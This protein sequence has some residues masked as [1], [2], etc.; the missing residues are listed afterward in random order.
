MGYNTVV[1]V[2][3]DALDV[4]RDDP[5]FG[6]HLY[7]AVVTRDR[8]RHS[9]DVP[10]FSSRGGIFCNAASVLSCEHADVPQVAVI[11]GNTGWVAK[12]KEEMPEHA[13][14]DMIWILEQHGYKVSKAKK[15]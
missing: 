3:N 4:I 6:Q 1:V 2:M 15:K 10:A 14:K 9:S 7:D 8:A 5:T 11:K 12:Y 13:L